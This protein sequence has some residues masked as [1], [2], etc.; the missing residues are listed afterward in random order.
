MSISSKI[1]QAFQKIDR[2]D[3]VLEKYLDEVNIDAPLPILAGQT[4]SQP[5]TVGFMLDLLDI[6]KGDKILDIGSGSGWTTA[7]LAYLTGKKGKVVGLEV[8]PELVEFGQNNL[9]KYNFNNAKIQKAGK[10]IGLPGQK[11]DKILVSAAA[12]QM[13][14]ELIDQIKVG[15]RLVIPVENSVYKVEKISKDK[16]DVKAYPGFVFVPLIN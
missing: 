13:P 14:K 8:V 15:G 9:S 7:L 11:F 2:K 5:S 1:Q 3:F 12:E 10:K 6:K 16:L 4:I